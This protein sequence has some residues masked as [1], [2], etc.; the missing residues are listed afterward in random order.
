MTTC[1]YFLWGCFKDRVYRTNPHTVQ[2]LQAENEDVAE[3]TTGDMLRDTDDIC[4]S[5]TASPQGLR[6]SY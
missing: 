1:D 5:F 4:G 2:Q 3:E 6:I